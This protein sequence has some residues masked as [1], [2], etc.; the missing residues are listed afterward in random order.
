MR[1]AL[2]RGGQVTRVGAG[3]QAGQQQCT[4]RQR[5][6]RPGAEQRAEHRA[7]AVPRG[8]PGP[9]PRPGTELGQRP[10]LAGQLAAFGGAAQR[11]QHVSHGLQPGLVRAGQRHPGQQR[12]QGPVLAGWVLA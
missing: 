10:G 7:P 9:P 8:G 1:P 2:D 11:G 4:G 5:G 3:G 6:G 12:V